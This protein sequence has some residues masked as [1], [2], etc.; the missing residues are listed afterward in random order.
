MNSLDN[1]DELSEL[2][3]HSTAT[4]E[5]KE[6]LGRGGMGS[7]YKGRRFSAAG[8]VKD[9]AIK[10]VDEDDETALAAL[11]NEAGRISQLRHDNIV[12]FV[13]S[14]FT[15]DDRMFVALQ[16]IPGMDLRDFMAL[17]RLNK[18][19]ICN[20]DAW[21]MPSPIAG[22]I[23]MMGARALDAAHAAG[24]VNR[25]VS[26]ENFVVDEGNGAVKQIDFG[27]AS[28]ISDIKRKQEELEAQ[29]GRCSSGFV[30][31]IMYMAPEQ[32]IDETTDERSDICSL[33]YVGRELLMGFPQNDNMDP[34]SG[35]MGALSYRVVNQEVPVES[36]NMITQGVNPELDAILLG[37]TQRDPSKRTCQTAE[38]LLDV[39]EPCLYRG[40]VGPTITTLHSYIKM[41]QNPD[42]DLTRRE[43]NSLEC[44]RDPSTGQLPIRKPL[45]MTSD[46]LLLLRK[47]ENPAY[48]AK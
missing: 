48:S 1:Q 11:M 41:M 18:P 42:V 21:S 22:F 35:F 20:G 8:H 2:L 24:V 3:S 6:L 5:F 12:D 44:L 10:I 19:L 29:E 34:S 39:L 14:G 47:G 46:A 45:V 33:G 40:G 27:I 17:H 43:S 37:I 31:K 38:A 4:Y 13:D 9:V 16:Y 28:H 7:V 25:D 32:I 30:G 15:T 36:L 23:I 26:P